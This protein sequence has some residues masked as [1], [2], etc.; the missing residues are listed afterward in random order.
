MR[1]I[2]TSSARAKETLLKLPLSDSELQEAI[3]FQNAE[4]LRRLLGLIKTRKCEDKFKEV[5]MSKAINLLLIVIFYKS[6]LQLGCSGLLTSVF[7]G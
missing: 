3:D 1:F 7:F 4:N 5:M 2:I 6:H